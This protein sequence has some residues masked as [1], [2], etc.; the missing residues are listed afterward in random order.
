M[1]EDTPQETHQRA[2]MS[3]WVSDTA[4]PSICRCK[5]ILLL[6]GYFPDSEAD[7]HLHT[8][9]DNDAYRLVMINPAPL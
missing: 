4:V 3:S 1:I 9:S 8:A 2:S 7:F 5:I 6:C